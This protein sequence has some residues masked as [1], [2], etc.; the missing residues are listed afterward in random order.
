VGLVDQAD[1]DWTETVTLA[2]SDLYVTGE[3]REVRLKPEAIVEVA[4]VDWRPES[5]RPDGKFV[6]V[7]HLE[8]AGIMAEAA[9]VMETR[10]KTHRTL[11]LA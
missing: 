4:A 7:P 3:E 8:A 9:T 10:R 2:A 5:S 11:V 1:I 6:P